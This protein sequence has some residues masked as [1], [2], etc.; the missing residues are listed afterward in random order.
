M[1]TIASERSSAGATTTLLGAT[2]NP[3]EHGAD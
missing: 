1:F 3:L 2:V